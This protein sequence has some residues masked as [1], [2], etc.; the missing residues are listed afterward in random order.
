MTRKP[1]IERS[2]RHT[3]GAG[4]TINLGSF[5]GINVRKMPGSDSRMYICAIA[6]FPRSRSQLG[7]KQFSIRMAG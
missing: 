1:L 6:W 3:P 5:F 4:V 7:Y 2:Y